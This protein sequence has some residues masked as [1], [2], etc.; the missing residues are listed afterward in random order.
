MKFQASLFFCLFFS[1]LPQNSTVCPNNCLV[2]LNGNECETCSAG[3][4]RENSQS[5]V[6]YTYMSI[7]D[8]EKVLMETDSQYPN[9][10]ICSQN[11][12]LLDDDSTKCLPCSLPGCNGCR[13]DQNYEK[14]CFSCNE[15]YSLQDNKCIKCSEN[16]FSC[17]E[18]IC[19]SCKNSSFTLTSAGTCVSIACSNLEGCLS[20]IKNSNGKQECTSCS[21]GYLLDNGKCS[22]C[23]DNCANCESSLCLKCLSGFYLF[24]S[25][26]CLPCSQENCEECP[27]NEC[28]KCKSGYL[29]DKD[30]YTC[31]QCSSN[32]SECAETLDTCTK[33][34]ES[35]FFSSGVCLSCS[36]GCSSC[37]NKTVC[38][39]CEINKV[40]LR[41]SSEITCISYCPQSNLFLF[42]DNNCLTCNT[43]FKY[44]SECD[45]EKCYSC[46]GN[47]YL[48]E[49]NSGCDA[50]NKNGDISFMDTKL[51]QKIPLTTISMKMKGFVPEIIV[52]CRSRSAFYF[53][54]GLQNYMNSISLETIQS[55]T[56]L[57]TSVL[58]PP[59]SGK[60]IL[61]F[62]LILYF[63]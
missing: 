30:T 20:C 2:C 6:M 35:T 18:Q 9:C 5:C 13:L 3:Y 59:N 21:A 26:I 31:S 22:G 15:G 34:K 46:L 32:C 16:C 41:N 17:N 4:R 43:R 51:C 55:F 29:I 39:K 19:L 57:M 33:C 56:G 24:D 10:S 28:S 23:S 54:F 11:Y 44:C 7:S 63:F 45:T 47:N 8:C 38:Q 53:A 36:D 42:E 40:M 60:K 50:C 12:G 49:D 27:N 25:N 61:F 62:N 48:L 14:T 37:T 58:I 52:S 1:F